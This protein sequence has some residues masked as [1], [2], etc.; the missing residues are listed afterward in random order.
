MVILEWRLVMIRLIIG[1]TSP[2]G[3]NARTLLYVRVVLMTYM[4]WV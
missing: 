4:G 1:E 2:D 3:K